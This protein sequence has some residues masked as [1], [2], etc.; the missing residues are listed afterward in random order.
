MFYVLGM[1]V[2]CM[3]SWNYYLKQPYC[4]F[5]IEETLKEKLSQSYALG[6]S[7]L[8]IFILQVV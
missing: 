2:F 6:A 1:E 4:D 8:I 3:Y 5:T 7:D